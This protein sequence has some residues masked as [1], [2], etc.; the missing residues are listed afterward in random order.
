M[1]RSKR[2]CSPTIAISTPIQPYPTTVSTTITGPIASGVVPTP[3][4]MATMLAVPPIQLPESAAN[5]V[6][7]SAGSMSRKMSSEIGPADDDPERPGG[8]HE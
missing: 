2:P 4:A 5:P 6:H 1:R 3:S 8:D 7:A